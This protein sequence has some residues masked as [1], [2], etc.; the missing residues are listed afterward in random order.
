MHDFS[1]D[2]MEHSECV[3]I[4]SSD[5]AECR[6][7]TALFDRRRYRWEHVADLVAA[8][9]RAASS[10]FDLV[11]V[12]LPE[13]TLAPEQLAQHIGADP[14][15]GR[16]P[17]IV[18]HK[19]AES[20][21]PAALEGLGVPVQFIT[22]PIEPTSVLVKVAQ[23]LRLRKLQADEG[24]FLSKVASQNVELRELTNRFQRELREAQDIQR[25]ILPTEL[26]QAAHTSF[27]A[28]YVPLE[29]VGGDLYDIWPVGPDRLGIFIGDV[30]GHGLSA[31]FIGAMTKMSLA[32]A[33]PETPDALLLGMNQALCPVMPEG[34]FVTAAVA[35]YTPATGE[36]AIAR[37]G[38][39]PPL[40]FRAETKTIE[41]ASP[42]GFPLGVMEDARYEMFATTLHTG[43][44]LLLVTDGI[45]ETADL[46]GH[47][48]GTDGLSRLFCEAA[49]T[50]SVAQCLSFLL[51]RQELFSEG[52]L[53]KDDITLV[54]LERR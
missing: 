16:F 27:A 1:P 48:L 53:I 52:R 47:L 14:H 49:A 51:E 45:T 40:I 21:N 4:V 42:R 3:L 23:Q 34:R 5:D 41:T 37:G 46:A 7:L 6:R 10:L 22:R 8:G 2:S 11:V 31:A 28:A 50:M 38:H 36:I 20:V 54:G 33:S 24:R 12:D 18:V 44:M 17:L 15:L 13:L 19:E 35:I 30:T 29:A 39:P 9:E 32:F 26:P 25:S 43:D